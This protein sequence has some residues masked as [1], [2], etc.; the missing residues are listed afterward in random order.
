[1][2]LHCRSLLGSSRFS[3]DVARTCTYNVRFSFFSFFFY[4]FL[5]IKQTKDAHINPMPLGHIY[6]HI[7]RDGDK[8]NKVFIQV[9]ILWF[10][11][12]DLRS[13]L[14]SSLIFRFADQNYVFSAASGVDLFNYHFI[15]AELLCVNLEGNRTPPSQF[16]S[17]EEALSIDDLPSELTAKMILR[18]H[19]LITM[20]PD[21]SM[22]FTL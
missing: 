16:S 9:S 5:A 8:W 22:R 4:Y 10:K 13:A 2:R 18:T 6:R 11:E 19:S 7:S 17:S 3:N 14:Q 21:L 15:S 20:E 12:H 1:M